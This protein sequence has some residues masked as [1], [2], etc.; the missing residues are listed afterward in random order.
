M[1]VWTNKYSTGIPQLDGDHIVLISLLNQMH[2]NMSEE[3]TEH[4]L[5]P[6]LAALV[7]YTDYHF[8]RE[9]RLMELSHY[10]DWISHKA[11]HD[12]F[13]D[14]IDDLVRRNDPAAEIGRRLR[15]LLSHWLFDH[16]V[17][18]DSLMGEWLQSQPICIVDSP[19]AV[20]HK[21]HDRALLEPA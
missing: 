20:G 16:I 7:N 5:G 10:P 11:A 3:K 2:I 18:A 6:V 4:A 8:K 15:R 17:R 12:A 19:L 21:V 13:R 1:L 14:R 9:E